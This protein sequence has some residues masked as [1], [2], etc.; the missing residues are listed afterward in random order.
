MIKRSFLLLVFI[1]VIT[2]AQA[3][4]GQRIGLVDMEYILENI[5]EYK[6]AQAKLTS[7]ANDWQDEV[8]K[9]NKEV[10][11]L[12]N[13]LNNER[14]LLTRELIVEKE[15]FIE[16]KKIDVKN[17]QN[18]YFG[19]KGDYYKLRQVLVKPI[20]D[21]VYNS[22]QEIAKKRGFAMV[23]DKSSELIFLYSDNKYDISELVLKTIQ[24]AKKIRK[25]KESSDKK[26]VK[27]EPVK[28]VPSEKEQK[29]NKIKDEKF[30]RTQQE[31]EERQKL[32][33]EKRAERK[34]VIEKRKA[35][36]KNKRLQRL[37][38]REEQKKKKAAEKAAEQ[39][40]K[41]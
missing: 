41:K 5:S 11:K 27:K 26:T 33:E 37:K 28:L 2:F 21:E 20:Q 9:A 16:L 38:E 39:K 8:D 1:N 19:T 22:V 17:L 25:A 40:K 32:I 35:E 15:E 7:K 3:Q 13:E 4:K 12:Q 34:R 6:E 30:K 29:V 23:L 36:V 31:K 14:I 24:R 10:V 18:K